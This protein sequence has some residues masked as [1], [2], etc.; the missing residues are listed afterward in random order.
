M[1]LPSWGASLALVQV[2]CHHHPTKLKQGITDNT[3]DIKW[4]TYKGDDLRGKARFLGERQL[5]DC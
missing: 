5:D 4:I 1:I 2:F 3:D